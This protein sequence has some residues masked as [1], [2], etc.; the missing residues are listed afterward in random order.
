LLLVGA[1]ASFVSPRRAA[2]LPRHGFCPCCSASRA[3]SPRSLWP[4]RMP[5]SSG[6]DLP[7]VP[8][9]NAGWNARRGYDVARVSISASADRHLS[10]ARLPEVQGKQARDGDRPNRR[11]THSVNTCGHK[12]PRRCLDVVRGTHLGRPH[13]VSRQ[14]PDT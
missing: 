11:A 10:R 2:S 7:E 6:R 3:S 13:M 5:G 4:T 14:R 12:R 1:T 8:S 9:G